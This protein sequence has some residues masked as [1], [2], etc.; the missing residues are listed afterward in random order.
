MEKG[1]ACEVNASSRR[2]PLVIVMGAAPLE[3]ASTCCGQLGLT[4]RSSRAPVREAA[5]PAHGR[6]TAHAPA[7]R[8]AQTPAAPGCA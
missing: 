2:V 3:L 5:A 7:P 6:H 8:A 4:G 1:R